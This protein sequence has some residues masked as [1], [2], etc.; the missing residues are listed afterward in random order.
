MQEPSSQA[1]VLFTN[2]IDANHDGT[3]SFVELSIATTRYF[4]DLEVG[5]EQVCF[6][7]WWTHH[8]CNRNEFL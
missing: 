6:I 5:S 4:G 3:L 7:L 2:A 8:V 1:P